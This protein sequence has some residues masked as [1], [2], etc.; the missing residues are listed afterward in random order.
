[1]AVAAKAHWKNCVRDMEHVRFSEE[2]Q[3]VWMRRMFG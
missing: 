3:S 2:N 1:V